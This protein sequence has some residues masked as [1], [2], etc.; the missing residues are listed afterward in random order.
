MWAQGLD[1]G[2]GVKTMM[3]LEPDPTST[4]I[5]V[6]APQGKDI[7]TFSADFTTPQKVDIPAA[8]P[9]VVD[10]SGLTHDAF[11]QPVVYANLSSILVAHYPMTVAELEDRALDFE[12][13]ADAQYR[14]KIPVGKKQV[15]LATA[16]MDDGTP[17]SGFTSTTGFWG[18]AIMCKNCQ[19]PA[20]VSVSILNPI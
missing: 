15:D 19:V 20:P 18:F 1:P 13:I 2:V 12:L 5:E 11:G 17:F 16:T 3:F 4:V 14:A 7:L 6:T 10:W 8:G 9:Y